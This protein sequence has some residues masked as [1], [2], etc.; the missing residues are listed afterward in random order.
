[1]KKPFS[2]CHCSQCRK[3]HGAAFTSYGSV[4]RSALLVVHGSASIKTHA[5]AQSVLREFCAE[6]GSNLF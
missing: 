3:G 5:S 2:H 4:P 6:Y 1:M